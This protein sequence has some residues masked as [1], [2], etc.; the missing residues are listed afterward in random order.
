[1]GSKAYVWT[2]D[3]PTGF[4][5]DELEALWSQVNTN[6][7][8]IGSNDTDISNLQADMLD[9]LYEFPSRSTESMWT[10]SGRTVLWSTPAIPLVDAATRIVRDAIY[11]PSYLVDIDSNF[12]VTLRWWLMDNYGSAGNYE[13]EGNIKKLVYPSGNFATS[14][15][16]VTATTVASPAAG[17]YESFYVDWTVTGV[18]WSDIHGLAFLFQR[19]GS[20]TNDTAATTLYMLGNRLTITPS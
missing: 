20:A 5:N 14:I 18:S 11:L 10:N 17:A 12:D 9:A 7:T 16:D 6:E 13:Y 2:P 1:M 3:T 15:L 19:N 8:N 4:L